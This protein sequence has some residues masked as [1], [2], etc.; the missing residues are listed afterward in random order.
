VKTKIS[1]FV[2]LPTQNRIASHLHEV[3]SADN[4]LAFNLHTSESDGLFAAHYVADVKRTTEAAQLSKKKTSFHK[5][6]ALQRDSENA[7]SIGL[8]RMR[9]TR[10]TLHFNTQCDPTALQRTE[11]R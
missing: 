10:F 9:L 3:V 8:S 11:D 6:A 4:N 5:S 1:I 2:H 7:I